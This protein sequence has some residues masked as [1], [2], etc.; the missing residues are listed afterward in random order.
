M[1][2]SITG[3]KIYF[4]IPI[5]GGIRITQT[6]VSLLV[7]TLIIAL[8]AFIMTRKITKRPGGKQAI[9]EKLV[10]M[11]TNLVT[12][13][14]GAHNKR[15]VPYIG[16]LFMSS[17]IGSVI[18]TTQI[19]RS[20]TADLSTTLAWALATIFIVWYSNI[21]NLGFFGWLKS[22]TE[23]IVLLTPMNIISEIATPVAMAF[24]HFG[25]VAG[26]GVLM[27]II[28]AALASASS[29]VFSWLPEAVFAVFPPVLQVGI[30]AILSIYFDLFSGF[31]Q[32]FVFSLLS[33]VYIGMAN[34]PLEERP[35]KVKGKK[36]KK[37]K[38]NKV[39]N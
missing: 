17:I 31:I 29:M 23:P 19:F 6:T 37:V 20:T 15:F 4:E 21:K 33:M 3:A 5:L 14:M 24:R 26:G 38:Q 22:F 2:I 11:L 34:P 35:Q 28:Y 39:E 7:V 27:T 8:A 18:G 10:V 30:P 25:N 16:T 36:V 1:D 13:T 12:D 9:V 32:A